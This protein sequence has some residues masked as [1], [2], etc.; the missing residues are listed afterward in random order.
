MLT[1]DET[2][3]LAASYAEE[4]FLCSES[5][6]MALA[7]CLGVESKLIPKIATGFGAGIGREGEVCGALSGAVMGLGLKFGRNVPGF[8]VDGRRPYWYATELMKGFQDLHGH[9]RCRDLLGLDL[10]DPEDYRKYSERNLWGTKCRDL[11][12][13]TT[14]QAYALLVNADSV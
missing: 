7:K 13:S 12:A 2:V 14:E 3:N 11:I 1:K 4:G 6:L 5:V 10:T 8:I 9:L